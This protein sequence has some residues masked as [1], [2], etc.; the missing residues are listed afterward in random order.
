[1]TH[2]LLE[3]ITGTALPTPGHPGNLWR[4]L[5]SAWNDWVIPPRLPSLPSSQAPP[6]FLSLNCCMVFCTA[7]NE[8]LSG[9]LEMKLRPSF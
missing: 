6:S 1:M 8:K 4:H 9:V 5:V 7:S 3:S 2:F